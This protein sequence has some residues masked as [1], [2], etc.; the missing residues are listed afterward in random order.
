MTN[1]VFVEIWQPHYLTNSVYI[2]K[3]KVRG[4]RIRICFTHDVRLK[5]KVFEADCARIRQ[6]PV[7]SNGKIDC[8]HVP[9]RELHEISRSPKIGQSPSCQTPEQTS[10]KQ[11]LPK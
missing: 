5:G 7:V 4:E 3:Y 10:E 8:Y 11:L 9:M 6:C 2:A 1:T